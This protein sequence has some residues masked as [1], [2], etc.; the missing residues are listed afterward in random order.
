M[1]RLDRI[2]AAYAEELD[3]AAHRFGDHEDMSRG[4]V[5]RWLSQ[6]TDDHL[7]VGAAVLQRIS[8]YNASQI[9]I[10]ARQ[11]VTVVH[12]QF[13]DIDRQAI[14]FVPV[15]DP[16]SSSGIIA[17]AIRDMRPRPRLMLMADIE[18]L[19]PGDIRVIVFVD[20]FSGTGN[21][22]REWWTNVEM[23]IRPKEATIAVALLVMNT[24]AR[25]R[26][27]EFAEH[28]LAVV[29]LSDN[30]NV[31]HQN[32]QAFTAAEK[33]TLL[34]YC[35]Q[36]HCAAQFMRGY[37]DCGLL[38]AFRHGCPNNSLPILWYN[39]RPWRALFHRSA[40]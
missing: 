39:A 35:S 28:A 3:E 14:V 40:L 38:I 9:R 17:R 33:T 7:E 8:Y 32:S 23:L 36:T 16:G 25:V 18:D 5:L 26:I 27:E 37:G 2:D 19:P 21:Q 4:H 20:D 6:F 11:L 29:E 12:D 30:S 13:N 31:L 34:H 1:P 24:R 10:M 15:G 22:L